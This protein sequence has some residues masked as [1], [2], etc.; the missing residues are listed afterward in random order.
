MLFETCEAVRSASLISTLRRRPHPILADDF[1][2]IALPS[3]AEL[4]QRLGNIRKAFGLNE[5][6]PR[7]IA[8]DVE[9][10]R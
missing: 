4:Q 2:K 6:D 3:L 8:F 9:P 1:S 7:H 5:A 10:D